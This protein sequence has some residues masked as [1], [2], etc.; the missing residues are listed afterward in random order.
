MGRGST[1]DTHPCS[2]QNCP[3]GFCP[4]V[5][6]GTVPSHRPRAFI[7]SQSYTP[8]EVTSSVPVSL[9]PNWGIMP[10]GSV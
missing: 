7:S 8:L 6:L 1:G 2:G 9:G 5:P 4:L 3:F 10:C